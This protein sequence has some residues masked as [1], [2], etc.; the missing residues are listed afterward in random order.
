[1]TSP[2]SSCQQCGG[3]LEVDVSHGR[4]TRRV[5][6]RCLRDRVTA[7]ERELAELRR[8]MADLGRRPTQ[9]PTPSA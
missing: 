8:E 4:K 7:L 2:A 6:C 5:P 3:L 9:D 1:M